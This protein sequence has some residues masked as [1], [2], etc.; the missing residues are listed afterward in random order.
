MSNNIFIGKKCGLQ[1]KKALKKYPYLKKFVI[2][3]KMDLGSPEALL[4]YNRAILKDFLGLDF[5]IPAGYLVPTICSRWFFIEWM[6]RHVGKNKK[7]LEVGT[8]PSAIL[9]LMLTRLG[10]DVVATEFDETAYQYACMN[11]KNNNLTD[12]ITVIKS[13]SSLPIIKSLFKNL[14]S[15]HAVITNPPQYDLEFVTRT[16]ANKVRG[17]VGRR[18]ELLG[19]E[20]G[21]EF[22]IQ[23]LEEVASY[24]DPPPVFFQLT[25]PSL[26]RVLEDSLK[27]HGFQYE[28]CTRIVG[29][30]TRLYYKIFFD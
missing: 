23:L 18:L 29:T 4:T 6:D 20:Q 21:H 30:R 17:F 3:G 22:I 9:A 26:K 8:G 1:I 19:G 28:S 12:K 14:D 27:N 25:L 16:S 15:F 7:V 10:H 24:H 13:D 2:N 11:V 5:D